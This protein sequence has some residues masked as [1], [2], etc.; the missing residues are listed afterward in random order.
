MKRYNEKPQNTIAFSIVSNPQSGKPFYHTNISH[1][2]EDILVNNTP[3]KEQ[4]VVD[5]LFSDKCKS[6]KTTFKSLLEEIQLREKLDCHLLLRIN[7][8][9]SWQTQQLGQVN[10]I[11]GH[12]S[13]EWIK[14]INNLKMKLENNILDLEKEK[15]KEYLECWR[16][17]MFLKK[18]L[19]IAFKEYWDITK[20]RELLSIK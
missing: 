10:S 2:L 19:M 11:K 8:D 3:M 1:T 12:Y 9:I 7:Q 17:L 13:E 5:R 4:G 16:D 15:R 6:L 14:E 20:K 18:Y